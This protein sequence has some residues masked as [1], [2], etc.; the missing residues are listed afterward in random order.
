VVNIARH[1]KRLIDPIRSHFVLLF[2]G[3][4]LALP[5]GS[6]ALERVGHDCDP[7][8]MIASAPSG[9]DVGSGPTIVTVTA[10]ST[11]P[12]TLVVLGVGFTPG[13]TVR[14]ALYDSCGVERYGMQPAVATTAGAGLNADPAVFG[15]F[16]QP[17]LLMEAVEAS[18]GGL[19]IVR[20]F[21]EESNT[22]SNAV[23]VDLPSSRVEQPPVGCDRDCL[24]G[25]G[26]EPNP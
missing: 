24:K 10:S 26:I 15:G 7:A 25:R 9:V 22:W 13:G 12:G 6:A 14:V 11:V 18:H 3:M 17:G 21:D 23:L 20:A 2:M 1:S 16:S 4:F 19:I 5:H 8:T